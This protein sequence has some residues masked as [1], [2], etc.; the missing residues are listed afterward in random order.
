[1]PSIT[2]WAGIGG[3]TDHYRCRTPG[4]A[5][6]RLGWDVAHLRDDPEAPIGDVLVLQRVVDPRVPGIIANLR[7]RSPHTLVVY[8]IDDWYDA[9]PAY[10]PARANVEPVLDVCHELMGMADLITT[11]TPELAE[12]YARLGRTAVLPNYLDPDLWTGN[13]HYRLSREHIHVG[14]MGAFNWRGGDLELLKDWVPGFLDDH[15]EVRFVAVGCGEL[16]DYLGIAGLVSPK[17]YPT[18]DN[19]V[20]PYE[21]LPAMLA[22]LDIGLVPLTYNR[23][24]QAKSWCKGLEYNAMGVPAVASPSREYRRFVDPGTNG[25]LVRRN[26]WA[27]VVTRAIDNLSTLRDGARRT[28]ARYF[29]DDHIGRWVDAYDRSLVAA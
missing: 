3:G 8:D 22:W 15:P 28:A 11:S 4:A 21:H 16:L 6:E 1:M 14:W 9:I 29:I 19:W 23:F 18:A 17:L 12:G 7:R 25:Y 20:R 26:N 10:N 13:D 24:N 2:F 27:D 5:L